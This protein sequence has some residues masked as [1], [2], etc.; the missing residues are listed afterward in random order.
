MVRA[1]VSRET[2]FS[3]RLGGGVEMEGS[4]LEGALQELL[5]DLGPQRHE[6]AGVGVAG[7]AESG[8]P[9]AEGHPLGPVIAWFD[10][11]GEDTVAR[12][13]GELG[14]D[15]ALRIGQ[16]VRTV[17]SVAKLGWLLADGMPLPQRWLGVPE[18]CL[19]LLTGAEA[20]EHSLA[21]RTGAYDV[22]T[23]SWIPEVTDLLGIAPDVFPAVATAGVAMGE[24]SEDGARRYGL[25]AGV[26]VT[27][28]GH[29]HL[30][31][32]EGLGAA[33]DDILNSVGT[34]ETVLRRT[35]ALPDVERALE[36]GLAVTVRPGGRGWVVLASARRSGQV[37]DG[38]VAELGA[39]PDELDRE[40]AGVID[41]SGSTPAGAAWAEA[42]RD[43]A[44][45]AAG[46]V[47]R[48][49]E[50]TGPASRLV[51]YGGGS[52]SRPWL[53]LKARALG[54]LPVFRVVTPDAV[55]RGAA[56]AGG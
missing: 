35:A 39:T 29:D 11:R 17:S 25:P 52:R 50:L 41:G 24:V 21:A 33:E 27:I 7:M 36:L 43:L 30:A 55:A 22:A 8:L 9:I 6:V 38:L 49:S 12:M 54:P 23:R 31:A 32:A 16:R 19:F 13:A 3:P 26:P 51:V 28:A 42:L 53:A 15:L 1:A 40:A 46:A 47:T 56:L 10:G 20:T 5:S 48:M 18:T 37:L 45:R 14:P 2:P 4:D 34:A 44:E